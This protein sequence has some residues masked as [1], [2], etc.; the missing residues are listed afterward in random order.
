M[1]V[2]YIHISR[3]RLNCKHSDVHFVHIYFEDVT[4]T[5]KK[6]KQ[7][8]YDTISKNLLIDFK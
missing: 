2:L 3:I 7:M 5:V 8:T 6:T 4:F 1:D